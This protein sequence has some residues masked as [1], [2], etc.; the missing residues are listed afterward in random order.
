MKKKTWGGGAVIALVGFAAIGAMNPPN[1]SATAANTSTPSSSSASN[2]A[3]FTGAGP[4]STTPPASLPS[5]ST[6]LSSPAGS[7]ASTTGSPGRTVAVS[8]MAA[9]AQLAGL[10]VKGRAPKTGYSRAQFGPAWT[11]DVSVA[12]GHNGCDTRNDILASDLSAI[13][14]KTGT[15]HCTVLTGTLHDPYTGHTISFTRGPRTSTAVQIDHVVALSN[16]W[17]TGAQQL[18]AAGRQNLANDPRNLLAVDGPSNET[19][20]DG[21]AATW[22]PANKSFRC[23]YVADQIAVKAAYHLWVT[24]PEKAA[25]TAVL[26]HCTNPPSP[27]TTG[28]TRAP[29]PRQPRT[30]TPVAPAAPVVPA[31]PADVYYPNCAAARAAGA[32]P[33]HR[34]Q[35]GYRSGLDRDHDGIACE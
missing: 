33:L 24:P 3:A 19:K 30:T 11:D 8:T 9:R 28:A 1:K 17:Q 23:I 18:G 27:D 20:S 6:H 31:P 34:G 26:A 32:A 35:P 21:D 29:A 14:Y 15:R 13:T 16:A 25:M 5:S 4:T 12:G 22:L 2:R 7:T 10:A